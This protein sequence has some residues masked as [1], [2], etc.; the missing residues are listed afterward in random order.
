MPKSDHTAPEE[1]RFEYVDADLKKSV[2]GKYADKAKLFYMVA[3]DPDLAQA[4][5]T[6]AEVNQALRTL[7]NARKATG[8]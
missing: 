5:P 2:R 1:L 7:L 6:A 3:I 8:E 4:F